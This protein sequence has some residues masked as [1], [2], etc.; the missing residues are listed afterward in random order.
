LP[1]YS[2]SNSVPLQLA[3]QLRG[4]RTPIQLP[5]E[6]TAID[7]I[8]NADEFALGA[9]FIAGAEHIGI[10]VSTVGRKLT[11][12]VGTWHFGYPIGLWGTVNG[13]VSL[14]LTRDPHD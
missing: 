5:F 4:E 12:K 2:E 8:D 6:A 1:F 11:G 3:N 13:S 14:R 7:T 10:I 9:F